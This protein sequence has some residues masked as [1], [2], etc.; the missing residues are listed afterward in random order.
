MA[1]ATSTS[2]PS[3]VSS[4]TA[5]PSCYTAVPGKNGYVPPESCNANWAFEPSFAAAVAL[6]TIFGILTVAHITLAIVHRKPFCWVMIMGVVWEFVAFVARALGSLDQQKRSYAYMSSL[7]FL[8]APL[9]INAFIYMVAG[10]LIYT[11][12]PDKKIGRVKAVSIG[13]YFVWLDILSFLVQATGGT[14]LDPGSSPD[15]QNIGKNIYMAGVGIQEFFILLFTVLIVLFHRAIL[16]LEASESA[17]A[18]RMWKWLTYALYASLLLITVRVI[19]R[20]VEFSAGM[21][22]KKNPLPFE[23]GY[24]LALDAMPMIIAILILAVIHPGLALKG[25]ESVF[26]SRRERKLEK[27][28]KKAEKKKIKMGMGPDHCFEPLQSSNGHNQRDIELGTVS[29]V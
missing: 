11:F 5:T 21:D 26:P 16:R 4:T 27:K 29:R 6:S 12:H 22:P 13:K 10:R 20:L 19:F 14:M 3:H 23:E 17:P 9:W 8:L 2:L 7:L 28:A 25:P 18:N 15:T 24:A 1:S